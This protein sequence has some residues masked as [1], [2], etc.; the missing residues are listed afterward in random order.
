MSFHFEQLE[1]EYLKIVQF[2]CLQTW[3]ESWVWCFL[4][5][6]RLI[7][8]ILF[9]PLK[10]L[11]YFTVSR[12]FNWNFQKDIEEFLQLISSQSGLS[13]RLN[14]LFN[15]YLLSLWP[16]FLENDKSQIGERKIHAVILFLLKHV[17]Y[18]V[19]YSIPCQIKRLMIHM[20]FYSWTLL[21]CLLEI[22]LLKSKVKL[23]SHVRVFATPWTIAYQPPP[24]MEFS[25]QVYWSGLPFASPEYLPNPGIKRRS[26]TLQADALP[27]EPPRKISLGIFLNNLHY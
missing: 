13:G 17:V 20:N 16:L 27:S 5:V 8:V 26:P 12:R 18:Y 21:S 15:S 3:H 22:W 25:K 1:T 9:F 7:C 23:F 24:S 6:M 2:V 19:I 11:S 14:F 4:G 10:K